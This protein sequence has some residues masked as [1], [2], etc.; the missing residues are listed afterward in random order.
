MSI[1]EQAV[2][3]RVGDGG[4][5]ERLVP[6]VNGKL[7][8]EDGSP[9]LVTILDDFEEIGGLLLVSDC[10]PMSSINRTLTRAQAA[11]SRGSRPSTRATLS[12][13]S[14]RGARR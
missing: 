3:D 8:G 2:H 5:T 13:S 12:S 9:A 14:M 7:A 6:M 4:L 10:R 1:V 11:S